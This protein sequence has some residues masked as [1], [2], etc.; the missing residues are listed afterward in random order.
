MPL[1]RLENFLKNTDGNILYV[2]PSDL[3]ATDSIENQG[4]SLTRPFKTIQRALLEAARFSY[5][6]GKNNDRFDKTTI[7]VY[8]GTHYIDNRP[9]YVVTNG[10]STFLQLDPNISAATDPNYVSASLSELSST[11]NFDIFDSANDL[12]KFNSTE[13]GVIL[14]R[15]TSITGLDLR[16]TKIRPLFVPD[17]ENSL[18]DRTAIF[19]VTGGC[20]F[21]QFTIF[22]GDLNGLVYKNYRT[23]K[24]T[25]SY[26]H[27][28]LTAFEYADGVNELSKVSI[29]ST[30]SSLT[31]LQMYYI[32]VQRAYGDSSGRAIGDYPSTTDLESTSPEFRIVGSVSS[33][34]IGITS[35]TSIGTLATVDTSESHGLVV[36]D[37]IRVSGISSDLYNGSF[38]VV[39]ISSERRFSYILNAI[40]ASS[41]PSLSA[42][43]KVIVEPDTVSGA[44]PYI[45]NTSLRS[46][47]GLNGIHADGSKASGFKSMIVAQFTGIGLQK[48][49]NAFVLYDETTGSYKSESQ[50]TDVTK[51]P[52]HLNSNAVYKPDYENFHIKASNDA[53]IQ[54]VSVFAIGFA[55]HFVSE[56]GGDQSVTNSNSNFGSKSLIAKGFRKES[57]SRDNTGYIT[58][59]I[60]P[61]N[62]TDEFTSISFA[63]LNVGLTTNPVGGANTSRIYLYE[64]TDSDVPPQNIIDG[65]RIGARDNDLLKVI[66]NDVEYSSPILMPIPGSGDGP[67]ARKTF[68]VARTNNQNSISSNILN[69]TSTHNFINGESVRVISDDGDL[70]DGLVPNSFYYVITNTIDGS[71]STSQIKLAKI[72]NDATVGTPSPVSITSAKGGILTIESRVTDKSP[73]ELG[74][75]IQYDTTNSNWYIVGSGTTTKNKI[76]QAFITNRSF[77]SDQSG[78]SYIER[79][80]DLRTSADTIYRLRYVIPK[81]FLSA[82]EPTPSFIIQESSSVGV[83]SAGEFSATADSTKQRNLKI[84]ANATY[85]SN[86]VTI[87]TEKPHGFSVSDVVIVK[88]VI[89]SDN[90]TGVA[91]SSYNDTYTIT[92][93]PSSKTFKATTSRTPGTF[94]NPISSRNQNLPTVSRNKFRNTY[95]I[96]NVEKIQDHVPGQRDGIYHLICLDASVSP[97]T[98]DGTFN[99]EKFSQNVGNLYPTLDRDNYNSDPNFARSFVLPYKIGDV[100]VNDRRNSVT[101]ES[102]LNFYRDTR[103]GYAVTFATS[104]SS[105]ITTVFTDVEHNLNTVTRLVVSTAGSGYAGIATVLY[106]VPLVG[107]GITGEGATANIRVNASGSII[108]VE[109]VDG[110]SAYGIGNTMRVGS[111]NGAVRVTHINTD[112]NNVVEV[113]G[114]GTTSNRYESNYNGVYRIIGIS[115]TRSITYSVT[116]GANNPIN[117]GIYTATDGYNGLF[118]VSDRAIGVS[119]IGYGNSAVGIVTVTTST[120]HGLLPGNQFKIVGAAQTIYNGTYYVSERVGLNTFTFNIGAGTSNPAFSTNSGVFVLKCSITSQDS[121]TNINSERI[122]NRLSN[123]YVGLTT[124]IANALTGTASTAR[125]SSLIGISTGEYFQINNEILRVSSGINT[126]TGVANVLRGVLGTKAIDHD[127]GSVIRKIK[128]IPTELRRYSTIRASGHT[129]EYLGFGHGNY[130]AALPARQTRVLTKNDQLLS[131]SKQSD[132]GSVVYT[133]MNDAGDFYLGN[134][135]ISSVNGEEE[136]I[137]A[138]I[139]TFLGDEVS[140]LSVNFDDVTVKNTLRVEGGPNNLQA[141]EFKGPVNFNNKVTFSGNGAEFKK[142]FLKGN[143]SQARG[144]TYSSSIPTTAPDAQGDIAFNALAQSGGYLGWVNTGSSANDWTRFGLISKSATETFVTPDRIGINTSGPLRG[145]PESGITTA[146][147]DVRGGAVFDSLR[148]INNADFVNGATF[149]QV[150]FIDL[151]VTGIATIGTFKNAS[152]IGIT[153]FQDDVRIDDNLYVAGVSTFVGAVTFQGGTINLGD[154]NTDNVIF[155]ADINS[156]LIPNQDGIFSIGTSSKRWNNFFAAGIGS[157]TNQTHSTA[158]TNGAVIVLGGIGI[159]KTSYFGQDIIC[160][161]S[162]TADSDERLKENIETID[163]ALEKTLQLR[164]VR[165]TKKFTGAQEIGVIAQEVEKVIPEVVKNNENDI[166]S[167]AYGNMV[168]LLIEAV[169]ELTHKVDKLQSEIDELKNN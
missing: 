156:D 164:G 77:L 10:G 78:R 12:Y 112:I 105:G 116:D 119:T 96:Y 23:D 106:N 161:G 142:I 74:H 14:P 134:K 115:S 35:I 166:K 5:N 117:A 94:G 149:Q 102:V 66:V 27:H 101:K 100:I 126:V 31:D 104:G 158:A 13:G 113:V 46:V 83:S 91:N 61:K 30:T 120:A 11:S 93:I 153:T 118:Y 45:F 24:Y 32:K 103:T 69:L 34:D 3:D 21:Y 8:P 168:G 85:S 122:A 86:V 43:P 18:I 151:Y 67:S 95:Y 148:V 42:S 38:S 162:V 154:S 98:S 80:P 6:I 110:G 139:Q 63:N 29:A 76:N 159:G 60:P 124:T 88:N 72:F 9:G 140:S 44:S 97:S 90:P 25:P 128:P 20:Y 109:V 48:D 141:S 82:K 15:G 136:T 70:P 111:G 33:S 16:K 132:G 41:A 87:T 107:V 54:D 65:Y 155:A 165:F 40:P 51:K 59:V 56:S 53:F 125:F 114:V 68:T 138:P 73:G 26:S 145:L 36:D 150:T 49:D 123:F 99:N 79:K 135:R 39:G 157:F 28:K 75:P 169:K 129:F 1:S 152:F 144:V 52:L 62:G 58:H 121:D 84:I 2:N 7:M 108:G 57:F 37:S 55:N 163:N 64:F 147:L 130:S 89:S 19:K 137:N 17:P 146:R 81:E 22:D 133:G 50:V 71:L 167:V 143:L 160:N 92:S 47:Y 131:Q 127:N 4:N